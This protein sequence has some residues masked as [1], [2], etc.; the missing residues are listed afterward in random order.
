MIRDGNDAQRRRSEGAAVGD[1]FD[2]SS[3]S[4]GYVLQTAD[5]QIRSGGES[6][7]GSSIANGVHRKLVD[8][9]A[10]IVALMPVPVAL[11][12]G[13]KL[14]QVVAVQHG[15]IVAQHLIVPI[16]ETGADLLI[17]HVVGSE[18][19]SCASALSALD[20]ERSA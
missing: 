19:L 5:R 16:P 9:A 11:I 17:V 7:S 15:K 2:R 8:E 3:R 13:A 6:G 14:E 4:S 10:T 18:I 20:F 1:V 12:H